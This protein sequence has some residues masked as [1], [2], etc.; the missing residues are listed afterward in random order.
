MIYMLDTHVLLWLRFNPDK[1]TAAQK[2]V[3][4]SSEN[5]KVV[6]SITAWEISLKF[7]LG[8]LELADH[9]PEEFI[10]GVYRLGLKIITPTAEQY[11]TYHL[12]PKLDTHK[13][14][15]DRMIVWHAIQ[16]GSTLVS[17]DRQIANYKQY[18]L[19]TL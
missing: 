16:A 6:S 17:S 5:E 7:S 14:P 3:I 12:L 8:K 10:A 15:F 2:A 11:A 18:G 13:D 9:T 4:E 1:L 19:L